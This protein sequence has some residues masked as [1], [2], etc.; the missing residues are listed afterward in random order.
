MEAKKEDSDEKLDLLCAIDKLDE[1]YKEVIILKYFDDL[2]ISEISRVLD[3]PEGT[4]K[5]YLNK[6]L[7]ALRLYIGREIV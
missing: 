5:T 2:T 4:I 7:N 3:K 1:R 6:G